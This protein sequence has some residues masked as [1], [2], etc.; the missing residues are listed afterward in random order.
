MEPSFRKLFLIYLHFLRTSTRSLLSLAFSLDLVC[1]IQMEVLSKKIYFFSITYIFLVKHFVVLFKHTIFL[2]LFL[3]FLFTL[4][5]VQIALPS[6]LTCVCVFII[7]AILLLFLFCPY[8]LCSNYF[9]FFFKL[10]ELI[11]GSQPLCLGY[12]LPVKSHQSWYFSYCVC[13]VV[14][15]ICAWVT[16]E[17]EFCE[18]R[19]HF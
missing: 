7:F 5:I 16:C 3:L 18:I 1:C 11:F 12:L 19:T 17:V 14:W 6:V 9:Q 8:R 2:L 15:P 4:L 13:A 10:G